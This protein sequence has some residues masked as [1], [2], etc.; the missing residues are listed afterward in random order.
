MKV[1]LIISSGIHSIYY[2][3]A[4]SLCVGYAQECIAKTMNW[5][6]VTT[7]EELWKYDPD[8]LRYLFDGLDFE[9]S[10]L[11]PIRTCLTDGDTVKA[12]EALV[13]YFRQ[14]NRSW[15]VSTMKTDDYRDNER[16]ANY[17]SSGS[18]ILKGDSVKIPIT[19]DGGW[20]WNHTGPEEDDEFGY[21]LNSHIYLKTLFI[22]MEKT[23]RRSCV[24]VFDRLI[25][26]WIIHHNLPAP[27][28]SIYVVLDPT[29]SVDWRDIG[30]V[31]WR[32]LQ[33]GRRLGDV[34][35]QLFYAF[36]DENAFSPAARLLILISICEQAGYLREYH[37]SGH[38]WTTVEMNGLA[39]AG[40]AF[41]EFKNAKNWS[42]YALEVMTN[43]LSQQV[44]PD[45][46]QTEL[47]TITQ[48]VALSRFELVANN[49]RR[50]GRPVSA[51]YFQRLEEMYDYL[52]Y[53]MRPDGHQP[54]NGDS[55]RTDMRSRVLQAA[56]KFNRPD[57]NW[58]A[59]NGEMG[60]IPKK[61][62]SVTYPWAGIHIMRNGWPKNAEWSFFDTG[63][64]GTGH[65]HRDK[66]H[67]SIAAFGKDLLVD[68]GRYT[69]KDYFS[70]DP[71]VWRR[72]FRSSFSHNVILVDGKGQNPGATTTKSALVKDIDYLHDPKYDYA[73]GMFDD[74]YEDVEGKAIHTRSVMYIRNQY[75]VVLDHLETDR[76]RDLQALWHYAPDCKIEMEGNEVVSN[77]QNEANLRIVPI[78]NIKWQTEIVEGQQAPFIQGWYSENYGVKTP[79]PTVVYTTTITQT[80]TFAWLLIPA[81]GPVSEVDVKFEEKEGLVNLSVR[82]DESLVDI[83]LPLEKEISKIR[84]NL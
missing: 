42:D 68:G 41:P 78:G 81:L 28:D 69:H 50:A 63:P 55:D 51:F 36:Q 19:Q 8:R 4:L 54:L 53:S 65:Q 61:G 45:G 18:V 37:K 57:W 77:N 26:D 75:W 64:Y 16:V 72:Y 7:A 59:T 84:V 76:P 17:L 10:A 38:N 67:L 60:E 24:E 46:V 6:K 52:A 30:E 49:Y 73:Y 2:I 31:E 5:E 25:K 39:L 62:P 20:Q 33:A 23:G 12:T 44:Y 35:P 74:G 13:E 11:E 3:M 1:H 66:L 58:I 32:T 40:L 9:Q 29:K 22:A 43:E 27:D 80:S 71:T 56:Q 14:S 70:F 15:V 79:N 47:S 21:S 48:W 83:I 34:W 82:K